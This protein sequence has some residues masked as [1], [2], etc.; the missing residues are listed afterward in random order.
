MEVE[1]SL[2]NSCMLMLTD[3]KSDD[4]SLWGKIKKDNVR[5]LLEGS[6]DDINIAIIITQYI[7]LLLR[8]KLMRKR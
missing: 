1:S 2:Q 6:P 4:S 7:T 8:R 5:L 3:T